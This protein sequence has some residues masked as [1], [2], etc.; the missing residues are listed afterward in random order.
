MLSPFL[1]VLLGVTQGP[2]CFVWAAEHSRHRVL[3][4]RT[5]G[6]RLF[7]QTSEDLVTRGHISTRQY[8]GLHIFTVP[9]CSR[10]VALTVWSGPS[11][12]ASPGNC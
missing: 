5:P 6:L 4:Q 10:P 8:S 9:Y 1:N 2:P 3:A 11:I 7:L 12:G